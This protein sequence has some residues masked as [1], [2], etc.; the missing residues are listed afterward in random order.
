[1][2]NSLPFERFLTGIEDPRSY[3]NQ[4][5][6]FRTLIGVSFLG[7]L[8]GLDSFYAIAEYAELNREE[9]EEYFDFPHGVPSHDTFARLWENLDHNQFRESFDIFLDFLREAAEHETQI[10]NIDGKTIRNSGTEE[11]KPLHM[12]SAWCA[13]NSL[14]LAQEKVSGKSN[15]ITAIPLLL[16]QLCLA[17]KIITIDAIGTQREICQQIIDG[18]GDYVV[19]LKGNQPSL[20]ADVRV[21]FEKALLQNTEENN[22]IDIDKGHGRIETRQTWIINAQDQL[23]SQHNWPGLQSAIVIKSTV[24]KKCKKE[25]YKKTEETRLYISSLA[26]TPREAGDIVRAH[27]SIENQLHWRLDSSF[28]ED[29]SCI[30]NENAVENMHT[31]RTW[32]LNALSQVRTEK[33]TTKGMLRKNLMSF[34][35]L[36]LNVK[37]IFVR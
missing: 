19:A 8:C 37:K 28:N 12:V 14:V 17:D 2:E 3:R 20:Q 33:D 5:H 1:M 25:G 36:M 30:T 21:C 24:E 32:A 35:K 34:R 22:S 9:L 6:S 16:K 7:I 27:W 18:S 4:K 31:L 10:I 23:L 29:K 26:L 15:E 11:H 13:A